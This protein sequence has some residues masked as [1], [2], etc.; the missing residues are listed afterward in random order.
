M[1]Y[2]N[3]DNI[4]LD[5]LNHLIEEITDDE[6]LTIEEK[7]ILK[8]KINSIKNKLNTKLYNDLYSELITKKSKKESNYFTTKII[9]GLTSIS[10]LGL[11]LLL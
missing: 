7:L 6:K 1:N 3:I 10:F 9:V 4:S 8:F 11:V 5:R 2:K